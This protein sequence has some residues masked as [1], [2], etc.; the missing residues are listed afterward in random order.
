MANKIIQNEKFKL[1]DFLKNF[2][3]KISENRHQ[4]C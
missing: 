3:K 1:I 2:S 4:K